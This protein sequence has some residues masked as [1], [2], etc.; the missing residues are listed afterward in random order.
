M[1][2]KERVIRTIT[3]D[4]PDRIPVDLWVLPAAKERYGPT[5]DGLLDQYET[6]IVS[7]NGPIDFSFDKRQFEVGEFTDHWGCLWQV[8]QSGVIGEVK[9]SP[10]RDISALRGYEPPYRIFEDMWRDYRPELAKRAAGARSRGKFVIGGWINF[11]E[12]MQF[13]R[14]V[15][16]FYCD[17]VEK[18]DELFHIR[19]IF[20][21][22]YHLYLD[23]WLAEDI[24]AVAIG[25][26][27]GSQRA[28]LISKEMWVEFFKPMYKELID[29]VRAAGKYVF[30]HSD[31][32]IFELYDQLVDLGVSA[33]NSQ[34]WCMGVEKVAAAFAGK[35]TF[36]GEVSRQT[37]LPAGTPEDVETAKQVMVRHLFVNGGGLIGEGEVNRD[38]PRANIEALLKPWRA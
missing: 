35:I 23:K 17:L 1:D 6:D 8:L 13:L 36:W 24:D 5:L 12:R 20:M 10:L 34:L 19:D 14:G 2:G 28:L 21:K 38:V 3:F 27:W 31:G 32:W 26:D 25:D 7:L 22:F 30:C 11:F 18:P 15:E 33:V 16:D 37:T 9:G 4:H 29:R